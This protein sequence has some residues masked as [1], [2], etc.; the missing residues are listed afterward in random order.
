[1]EVDQRARPAAAAVSR[2]DAQC[3][4]L[5]Q[6][7]VAEP[8]VVEPALVL[9]RRVREPLEHARGEQAGARLRHVASAWKTFASRTPHD[10]ERLLRMKPSACRRRRGS[11]ARTL[12][13]PVRSRPVG[14]LAPCARPVARAHEPH[15]IARHAQADL[16]LGADRPK[17]DVRLELLAQAGADHLPVVAAGVEVDAAADDDAGADL[18]ADAQLGVRMRSTRR[19]IGW[20]SIGACAAC[21]ALARG[22]P[23]TPPALASRLA[24]TRRSWPAPITIASGIRCHRA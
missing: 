5:G 16:Q 10:G 2:K 15:G 14:G 19:M 4:Q 8:E 17:L 9:D 11:R 13:R 12:H 22:A 21:A 18:I 20:E 24:A 6:E 3:E 7:V 1:M 23:C